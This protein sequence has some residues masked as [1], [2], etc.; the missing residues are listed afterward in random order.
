MARYFLAAF[1]RPKAAF[2]AIPLAPY[3]LRPMDAAIAAAESGDFPSFRSIDICS[4]LNLLIF[5]SAH[6]LSVMTLERVFLL[7]LGDIG[8]RITAF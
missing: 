8:R 3:F 5:T 1:F 6:L 2:F 4:F 7:R